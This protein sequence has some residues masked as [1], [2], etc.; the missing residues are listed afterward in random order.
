MKRRSVRNGFSGGHDSENPLWSAFGEGVPHVLLDPTEVRVA[1]IVT[2]IRRIEISLHYR[3]VISTF[4]G[5][6]V[7][8]GLLKLSQ[9]LEVLDTLHAS[10]RPEEDEFPVEIDEFVNF[11][12]ELL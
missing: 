8:K 7:H 11:R 3:V 12:Q 9:D 5:S 10:V 2:M 6:N 4:L 1:A